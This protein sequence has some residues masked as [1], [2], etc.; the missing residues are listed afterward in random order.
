MAEATETKI[1][2]QVLDL[3]KAISDHSGVMADALANTGQP[4]WLNL[5]E[6]VVSRIK[7]L[8]KLDRVE[9]NKLA[10]QIGAGPDKYSQLTTQL[11]QIQHD[12]LAAAARDYYHQRSS[13]VYRLTSDIGLHKACKDPYGPLWYGILG[14]IRE[15]MGNQKA[16]T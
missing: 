15:M 6:S 16:T 3:I 7:L 8:A 12:L 5:S 13:R 9:L 14:Y 4:A 1:D 2:Q 11:L 10:L